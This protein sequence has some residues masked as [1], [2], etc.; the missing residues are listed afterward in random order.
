VPDE[1]WEMFDVLD[2]YVIHHVPGESW[3]VFDVLDD[4]RF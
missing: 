1:S 2:D 3:E 4:Y